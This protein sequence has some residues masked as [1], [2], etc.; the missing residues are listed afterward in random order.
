MMLGKH[1]N[2]AQGN[3]TKQERANLMRFFIW[4]LFTV[5][6][7]S[8]IAEPTC[9][10]FNISM[11]PSGVAQV[12]SCKE[13]SNA[14][15]NSVDCLYYSWDGS[16]PLFYSVDSC[17]GRW[18]AA[19]NSWDASDN[20]PLLQEYISNAAGSLYGSLV[21]MTYFSFC[22][23]DIY[24]QTVAFLTGSDWSLH[25]CNN[26]A[27]EEIVNS[28][29]PD[30]TSIYS[31]LHP[32]YCQMDTGSSSDNCATVYSSWLES[33]ICPELFQYFAEVTANIG[34][35][36][37]SL[38]SETLFRQQMASQLGSAW[39]PCSNSLIV[40]ELVTCVYDI[41]GEGFVSVT[42]DA[43]L[44]TGL[45]E[46]TV[47]AGSNITIFWTC[48]SSL[49]GNLA[50]TLCG[51]TWEST[52]CVYTSTQYGVLALA[53]ADTF[54]IPSDTSAGTYYFQLNLDIGSPFYS[55]YF[56][57]T[58][59]GE[60]SITGLSEYT[61]GAGSNITVFWTNP[62]SLTGT[63]VITLCE[64]WHWYSTVDT[65]ACVNTAMHHGI[66]VAALAYTFAIPSSTNTDYYY[67]LFESETDSTVP[68]YASEY[69]SVASGISCYIGPAETY[70]FPYISFVD[71]SC[72]K[73]CF[74][75]T[76]GDTGC[77]ASQISSSAVVPGYT[78]VLTSTA[79]L[80]TDPAYAMY[81]IDA[82]ACN[83]TNCNA[84]PLLCA[85]PPE[86][87]KTRDEQIELALQSLALK[88]RKLQDDHFKSRQ[89]LHWIR[90]QL[91]D[92]EVL[93]EESGS[94]IFLSELN[95]L[96]RMVWQLGGKGKRALHLHPVSLKNVTTLQVTWECGD[97]KNKRVKIELFS[98]DSFLQTL[99]PSIPCSKKSFSTTLSSS[100]KPGRKFR[101]KIV[102]PSNP[103]RQDFSASFP[104]K[105]GFAVNKPSISSAGIVSVAWTYIGLKSPY[106][107]ISLLQN[108]QVVDT[109][110]SMVK[111]S[112]KTFSGVLSGP[113]PPS[114]DYIV[115]VADILDPSIIGFSPAFYIPDL[116]EVLAQPSLK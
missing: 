45:S 74:Q 78:V 40:N 112:S 42:E 83:T 64:Y 65:T 44:V 89:K 23:R 63:L 2:A 113:L 93:V 82:A 32:A 15:Y 6:S 29:Y 101:V 91:S 14:C 56:S 108:G 67:F 92:L 81:Y 50:I 106:V 11:A 53:L 66:P 98:G 7:E 61:V 84:P 86:N 43:I 105:A 90:N 49:T 36:S 13:C 9:G 37:D 73:Y 103:K 116:F 28:T 57:V 5:G 25:S 16:T 69:F 111:A 62:N 12:T 115:A 17:S 34:Q 88:I 110:A 94:T 100:L 85:T 33:G 39:V 52:E 99:T 80:M 8:A 114:T 76:P 59:A 22:S 26:P 72:I 3:A 10:F 38:S 97:M 46:S 19:L 31:L 51:T 77:T 47:G 21:H 60:V 109:I 30:P 70:F 48:P 95:D 79:A 27:A 4:L 102:D 20:C 96:K 41:Y 104:I 87:I 75:C 55:D 18:A 107:A 35:G 54:T 68:G 24:I 71:Y 58:Q 1:F